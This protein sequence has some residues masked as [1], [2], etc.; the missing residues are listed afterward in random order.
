MHVPK[1]VH[2]EQYATYVRELG[3]THTYI[4]HIYRGVHTFHT[5]HM[6]RYCGLCASV[7]IL[8]TVDITSRHI[9]TAVI[10]SLKSSLNTCVHRYTNS[11]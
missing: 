1:Y 2:T 10:S 6:S 7:H 9:L 3:Y 8:G 5:V 4:Q 11:T